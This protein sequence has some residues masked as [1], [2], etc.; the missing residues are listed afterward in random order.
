MTI[1]YMVHIKNSYENDMRHQKSALMY[2]FRPR[3][4][5]LNYNPDSI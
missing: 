2:D 4:V 5:N 1:M 3:N